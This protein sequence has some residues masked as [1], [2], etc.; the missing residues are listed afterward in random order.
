M[1]VA[2]DLDEISQQDQRAFDPLDEG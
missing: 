2:I 1:N